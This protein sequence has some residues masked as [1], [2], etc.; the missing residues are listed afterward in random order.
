MIQFRQ[1]KY[2]SDM[3]IKKRKKQSIKTRE[4]YGGV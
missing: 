4:R 3:F 2:I 1:E